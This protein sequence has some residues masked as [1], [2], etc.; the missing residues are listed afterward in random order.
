MSSARNAPSGWRSKAGRLRR[1]LPVRRRRRVRDGVPERPPARHGTRRRAGDRRREGADRIAPDRPGHPGGH[2]GRT[3]EHVRGLRQLGR[4]AVQIVQLGRRHRGVQRRGLYT[5]YTGYLRPELL[6]DADDRDN[7]IER[8]LLHAWSSYWSFE[9]FEER[10]LAQVDHLSGAMGLTVHARFDDDLEAN[11]GVATLTYMPDGGPDDA[12]VEINVQAG[13]VE[14]TNPDTDE[15]EFPEVIR[16]TRR[17]G[18]ISIERLAGSTLLDAGQQVLDDDGVGELFQQ[19]SAVADVWRDRLNASLPA[20]QR[21]QTVVLDYEFKTMKA[22][23]PHLVDGA[24]PYPARLVL[25]QVRSLDP[26]LR[27]AARVG[28]HCPFPTTC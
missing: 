10:R 26:G 8:A 1:P 4:P 28:A 23:W 18:E 20:A 24:D 12:V 11:N 25:R 2:R 27:A 19:V 16:V 14:V 9:A 17:G 15:V 3:V 21:V 7:T 5:S 6:D 22:G 13:S